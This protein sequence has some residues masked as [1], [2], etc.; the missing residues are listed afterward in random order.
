VAKTFNL[1]NAGSVPSATAWASDN[2]S[3]YYVTTDRIRT[4]LWQ[5]LLNADSPRLIADL[6]D[7]EIAHFAV[8]PDGKS[9]AFIRGRWIH[10]A[11]LIEGL[12]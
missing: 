4:S 9:F 6:G 8:S 3:F 7:E 11:V 12:K 5:Q 2:Q 10:D 1:A